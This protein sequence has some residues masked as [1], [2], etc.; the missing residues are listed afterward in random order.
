MIDI[1]ALLVSGAA[2][3]VALIALAYAVA[4]GR[5][6]RA[7]RLYAAGLHGEADTEMARGRELM[8]RADKL[9]GLGLVRRGGA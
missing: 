6:R 8:R 7:A 9:C 5:F 3:C 1:I 4:G 2:A